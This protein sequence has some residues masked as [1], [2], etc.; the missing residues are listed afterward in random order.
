MLAILD[1]DIIPD[2]HFTE[3]LVMKIRT[4]DDPQNLRRYRDK[5]YED[6]GL[7]ELHTAMYEDITFMGKW[8][9]ELEE[10]GNA[11]LLRLVHRG[12]GDGIVF[13]F[14]SQLERASFAESIVS[15]GDLQQVTSGMDLEG[16][17]EKV[18]PRGQKSILAEI[19]MTAV[20]SAVTAVSLV[21]LKIFGSKLRFFDKRSV[22]T[23]GR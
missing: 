18:E 13:A 9:M 7:K 4:D 3:E 11:F 21:A 19:A 12:S 20:S 14:P 22:Q 15:I 2:I 17:V 8:D 1:V 6:D 10:D 16:L 5:L 23:A